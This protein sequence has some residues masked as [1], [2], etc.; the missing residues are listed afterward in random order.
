M[1]V[2]VLGAL[3]HALAHQHSATRAPATGPCSFLTLP[4]NPPKSDPVERNWVRSGFASLSKKHIRATTS[5]TG[6]KDRSSPARRSCAIFSGAKPRARMLSVYLPA[7]N[8]EN[9]KTP[10][11]SVF[12]WP[13]ATPPDS[14]ITGPP[15]TPTPVGSCTAP[16][17]LAVAS[18][19]HERSGENATKIANP[20]TFIM[21]LSLL[22]P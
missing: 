18:C 21:G 11:S 16:V 17:R 1:S 19:A 14:R 6:G 5:F 8:P 13:T 15:Q 20:G 10:C 22:H 3:T 7:V 2:L 4:P 12:V 9:R